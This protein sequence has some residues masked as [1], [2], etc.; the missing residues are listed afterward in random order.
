MGMLRLNEFGLTGSYTLAKTLEYKA[1]HGLHSAKDVT[2]IPPAE[3]EERFVNALEGYF[4]ACPGEFIYI[5]L[6]VN[7]CGI[8]QIN[9]PS[10]WTKVRSLMALI[11][12]LVCCRSVSPLCFL[13]HV[14]HLHYVYC[15]TPLSLVMVDY[16]TQH[17]SSKYVEMRACRY[18]GGHDVGEFTIV[19]VKDNI[20]VFVCFTQSLSLPHRP[21]S[22]V[23]N[24]CLVGC[25]TST[26]TC[27]LLGYES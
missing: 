21:L 27:G 1:K 26:W 22:L 6:V 10:R 18:C 20:M 14:F 7:N 23:P 2:V 13:W 19:Y 16:Y 24:L 25:L 17:L 11:S 5:Q 15:Y 9:G 8:T 3:Y 12:C 4:V